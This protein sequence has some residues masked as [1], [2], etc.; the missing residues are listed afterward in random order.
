MRMMTRLVALAVLLASGCDQ[1]QEIVGRPAAPPETNRL[2]ELAAPVP[3][4]KAPPPPSEADVLAAFQATPSGNRTDIDLRK[5]AEFPQA[6]LE[7]RELDLSHSKVTDTGGPQLEK[8]KNLQTLLLP[9]TRISDPTA[10]AIARLDRL[11]RL[12]LSG[13]QISDAGMQSFAVLKNLRELRLDGNN[14]A[15]TGLAR[16]GVLPELEA[17]SVAGCRGVSGVEFT[18]EVNQG[19]FPKLRM[20]NVPGTRFAI[21]GLP[22]AARLEMLEHLNITDCGATDE[23]IAALGGCRRLLILEAATNNFGVSGCAAL[24]K[25][26]TLRE[27]NLDNNQSIKDECFNSLKSLRSLE[28]LSLTRTACTEA[29]IRKLK[30]FLPNTTIR[31]NNQTF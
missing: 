1:I 24:S 23:A 21:A 9:H 7:F 26:R 18:A 15:D 28:K 6:P 13:T 27:L 10:K 25:V 17:L 22:G 11:E 16:F 2:K 30:T 19:G 4:P 3:V 5:L 31:F 14:L 29:G 20:L 8:F 12:D